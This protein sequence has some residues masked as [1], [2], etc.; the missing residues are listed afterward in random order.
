[1]VRL[2][3][4][5]GKGKGNS[6]T[7]QE[8]AYCQADQCWTEWTDYTQG[9]DH[10][11]LCRWCSSDASKNGGAYVHKIH[12]PSSTFYAHPKPQPRANEASYVVPA[13]MPQ[14]GWQQQPIHPAYQAQGMVQ[15]HQVQGVP[16]GGAPPVQ[17]QATGIMP[18]QASHVN[19]YAHPAYSGQQPNPHLPQHAQYFTGHVSARNSFQ[20]GAGRTAPEGAVPAEDPNRGSSSGGNNPSNYAFNE[21][22][23]R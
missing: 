22:R 7:E 11:D 18:Q 1:M 12:G 14:H 19:P 10:H 9:K 6:W 17:G 15:G 16:Q 2:N 8:V 4:G 5:K 13:N 20:F 23:Q 3:K 21:Q